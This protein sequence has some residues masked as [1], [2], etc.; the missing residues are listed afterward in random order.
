LAS[1]V[2]LRSLHKEPHLVETGAD[3]TVFSVDL[4]RALR[5]QSVV[6][7]ERLGGM[8]EGVNTIIVET[9]IRLT[10]E[11]HGKVTFRGQYAAVT[12]VEALDMCV[13][14]RDVTNLFSLIVDWPQRL[15]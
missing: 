4:H 3:R 13:L 11:N 5:L 12:R 15:V 2:L 14:G 10:R 8:G 1:K 7:E 6:A 9:R